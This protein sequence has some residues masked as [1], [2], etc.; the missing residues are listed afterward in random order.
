MRT[1]HALYKPTRR[2]NPRRKPAKTSSA[3]RGRV[4]RRRRNRKNPGIDPQVEIKLRD[5][6]AAEIV[7]GSKTGTD[8]VSTTAFN[9]TVTL[10]LAPGEAVEYRGQLWEADPKQY[11]WVNFDNSG[12][13]FDQGKEKTMEAAAGEA[14]ASMVDWASPVLTQALELATQGKKG[15]EKQAAAKKALMSFRFSQF[16]SDGSRL[17]TAGK[18]VT[19]KLDGRK[20]AKIFAEKPLKKWKSD[21]DVV[22]YVQI[23]DDDEKPIGGGKI[24]PLMDGPTVENTIT[25]LNGLFKGNED[26]IEANPVQRARMESKTRRYFAKP[27][28]IISGSKNFEFSQSGLEAGELKP[29][30]HIVGIPQGDPNAAFDFGYNMGLL[31]GINTCRLYPDVAGWWERRKFRKELEKGIAQASQELAQGVMAGKR[32]LNKVSVRYGN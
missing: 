28:G 3:P 32:N 9:P 12:N 8:I 6:V 14:A 16:M 23:L 11:T 13:G 4:T 26:A 25:S 20:A 31:R 15:K 18:S 10:M 29:M 27:N 30:G 7:R 24:G 21:L 2:K 19:K 17:P 22:Y 5:R 1:Y